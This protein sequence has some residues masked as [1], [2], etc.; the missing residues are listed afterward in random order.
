MSAQ[1]EAEPVEGR[2]VAV[3][4]APLN[5]QRLAQLPHCLLALPGLGVEAN[6]PHSL[7]PVNSLSV[8]RARSPEVVDIPWAP[9]LGMFILWVEGEKGKEDVAIHSEPRRLRHLGG[10]G[11]GRLRGGQG[12]RRDT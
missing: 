1:L 7:F 11:C 2:W 12:Q 6:H 5:P 10:E 9:G 8:P 4:E 3:S